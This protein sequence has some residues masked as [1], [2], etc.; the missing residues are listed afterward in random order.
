M[1]RTQWIEINKNERLHRPGGPPVAP[2]YKSRLAV[3]GD[4][5]ESLGILADS[6]TCGLEGLR[7]IASWAAGTKKT[8]KCADIASAYFQGQEFDRFMLLKPPPDGVEG[9]P[10][11][12][13]LIAR[14]PVHGAR[15]AGRGLWQKIRKRV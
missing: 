9:V 2:Q 14:M 8:L 1:A 11:G 3:R 4:S 12:G 15:D 7:L 5:E 6:L 10:G 13:A